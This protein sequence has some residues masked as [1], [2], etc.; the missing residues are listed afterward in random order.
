MAKKV[1]ITGASSGIGYHL[2]HVFAEN[3][4]DVIGIAR[5]RE[6]LEMMRDGWGSLYKTK[7]D[8]L[9]CDLSDSNDLLNLL[10]FIEKENIHVLINNAGIGL[11]GN[12][13]STDMQ[14]NLN[15]IDVNIIALTKVT[16]HFLR[17]S[18]KQQKTVINISSIAGFYPGVGSSVYFAS[19]AYVNSFSQAIAI[20]N[21]GQHR[22]ICVCPGDTATNF[23]E[24][25]GGSAREDAVDPR[26]VA[27]FVYQAYKKNNI[28]KIFG[29]R[30]RILINLLKILPEFM[31]RK[32]SKYRKVINHF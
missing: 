30:N 6:I 5:N 23:F 18:K 31:V 1:L 7:F 3:G 2:C 11:Y 14:K 26:N 22:V 27:E 24:N 17:N 25:A 32:Y 21:E 13:S 9:I 29:L 12:F 16:Y 8:F 4:F 15:I 10:D 28:I 19:K 20:E